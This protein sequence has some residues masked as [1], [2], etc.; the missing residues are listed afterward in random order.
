MDSTLYIQVSG[1][2]SLPY[3]HM[4]IGCVRC[5]ERKVI[6]KRFVSEKRQKIKELV[7]WEIKAESEIEFSMASHV[8]RW[9]SFV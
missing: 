7:E 2:I 8:S 6:E 9:Q 4:L 3:I 5:R 1:L